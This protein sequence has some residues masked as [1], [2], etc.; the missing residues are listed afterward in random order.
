MYSP[1]GI[2][3]ELSAVNESK[4]YIEINK[5]SPDEK[6]RRDTKII[7]RSKQEETEYLGVDRIVNL[8]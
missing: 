6:F 4:P 1:Q 5:Y 2:P 8:L 7:T 3:I